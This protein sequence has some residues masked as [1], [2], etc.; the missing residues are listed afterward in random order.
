MSTQTELRPARLSSLKECPR[1]VAYQMTGAPARD[2][3]DREARWLYRGRA[4]GRDYLI[5]LGATHGKIWAASG[6][7]YWIPP[8]LRADGPDTAAVL[9]EVPVPWELGVGHIDGFLPGSGT[10]IEILSSAQAG[11]E[12]IYSKTLQLTAYLEHYPAATGGLL[13]VLNPSDFSEERF[14]VARGTDAYKALAEEVQDRIGQVLA[15]KKTGTMPSRVCRKPNDAIGHF[16]LHAETCFDGWEEPPLEEIDALSAR[17]TVQRF[18]LAKQA[19]R[20]AASV[21]AALEEERKAIQAEM[22]DLPGLA[23]TDT[24]L[25]VGPFKVKRTPVQ[26]APVLDVKKAELAGALSTEALADY[27]KPGASY[28]TW[29][30]ERVEADDALTPDDFGDEAPF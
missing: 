6:Q 8:H 26:R 14:P 2:R 5:W 23:D 12:Q 3:T 7:H 11:T 29:Y 9:A 10:A 19:E 27:M 15:W 22:E 4:L 16:C 24:S 1:M 17:E 30:V 25:K 13:V 28:A 18:Y 20:A 21:S